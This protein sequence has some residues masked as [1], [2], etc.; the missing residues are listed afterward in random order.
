MKFVKKDIKT[1]KK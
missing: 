1:G